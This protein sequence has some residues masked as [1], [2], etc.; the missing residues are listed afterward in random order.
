MRKAIKLALFEDTEQTRSDLKSALRR[1]APGSVIVAFDDP[2]K[3]VS[4]TAVQIS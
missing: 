4:P 2:M 1:A 3:R